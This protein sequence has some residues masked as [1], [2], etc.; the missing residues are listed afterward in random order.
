MIDC[1]TYLAWYSDYRDGELSWAEREEMED[2]AEGCE[3][4]ARHDHV[5]HRGTNVF[6]ALPEL[7]VSDDFADRLQWRLHQ[8]DHEM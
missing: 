5:V 7:T 2:H 6:R 8:T 3:S 4:C 1:D